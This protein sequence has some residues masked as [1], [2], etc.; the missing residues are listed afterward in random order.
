MNIG[1]K[2]DKGSM[3]FN[4]FIDYVC[5]RIYYGDIAEVKAGNEKFKDPE[6]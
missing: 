4:V 3:M 6:N 5:D 2:A 1:G